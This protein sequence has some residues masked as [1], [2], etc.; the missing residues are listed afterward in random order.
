RSADRV[1][2]ETVRLINGQTVEQ[3]DVVRRVP[4]E[5]AEIVTLRQGPALARENTAEQPVEPRKEAIALAW[6]VFLRQRAQHAPTRPTL[7]VTRRS[8]EDGEDAGL[9]HCRLCVLEANLLGIV[10]GFDAGDGK[11]VVVVSQAATLG[12]QPAKPGTLEPG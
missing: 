1:G 5:A 2:V 4:V 3:G 11:H 8:I 6:R 12:A 7:C 9:G 10:I